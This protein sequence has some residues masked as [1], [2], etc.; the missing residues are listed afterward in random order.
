MYIRHKLDVI[1]QLIFYLLLIMLLLSIS[2]YPLV[3]ITFHQPELITPN[4]DNI[5]THCLQFQD[6]I[7]LL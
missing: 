2:L 7:V 6:A 1:V 4:Q 3:P 5:T